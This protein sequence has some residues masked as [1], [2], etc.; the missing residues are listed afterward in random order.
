M[1]PTYRVLFMC[2]LG[3]LSVLLIG[4]AER[5]ASRPERPVSDSI[6]ATTTAPSDAKTDGTDDEKPKAV[7]LKPIELLEANWTELQALIAE[8]KGK[9][10]V[11]DLWSTAC[12]PCMKEFP[13]LVELQ[14]TLPDDVQAISFDLDFAGIKNKPVSY[15]RERVLNFLGSQPESKILHRMCSKAADE[16]FD[17]IQLNSIPAVYVFDREGVLAKRFEGAEDQSEGAS[18]ATNVIPFVKQLIQSP[19]K[20]R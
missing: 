7:A 14:A 20:T 2:Q 15:Y 18:Y 5:V 12:E 9:I 13:H 16:L 1:L 4:C 17:E 3:L 10:V 6:S 11:V 8:Q 19:G